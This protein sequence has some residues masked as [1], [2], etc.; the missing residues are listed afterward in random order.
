MKLIR[1]EILSTRRPPLTPSYRFIKPVD[2]A[3]PYQNLPKSVYR[4]ETPNASKTTMPFA[5]PVS[6][7]GGHHYYGQCVPQIGAINTLKCQR[8]GIRIQWLLNPGTLPVNA[9]VTFCM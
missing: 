5:A 4:E 2:W 9:V 8:F 1:E 3:S 6:P 7:K